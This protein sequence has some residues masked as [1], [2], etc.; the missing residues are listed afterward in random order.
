[1]SRKIIRQGSEPIQGAFQQAA[2]AIATEYTREIADDIA[3]RCR[4]ETS[5]GYTSYDVFALRTRLAPFV[6]AMF[7]RGVSLQFQGRQE[8]TPNN[9]T[10][11]HKKH[12]S[13]DRLV[14]LIAIPM[15]GKTE[16]T[17]TNEMSKLLQKAVDDAMKLPLDHAVVFDPSTPI[18][19]PNEVG[20]VIPVSW[21]RS[22]IRFV[23]PLRVLPEGETGTLDDYLKQFHFAMSDGLLY[24]NFR[25]FGGYNKLF[26]RMQQDIVL[27]LIE[28]W[29]RGYVA[30]AHCVAESWNLEKVDHKDESTA[31][32]ILPS[33]QLYRAT[34]ND[35]RF[36]Y[37][38]SSFLQQRIDG[39]RNVK[40][41]VGANN[42]IR[43]W[44]STALGMT[45]TPH[46]FNGP[47]VYIRVSNLNDARIYTTLVLQRASESY[48]KSFVRTHQ[49]LSWGK[50]YSVISRNFWA[51]Q[52]SPE[53]TDRPC[54]IYVVDEDK[55]QFVFSCLVPREM[56]L[57]FL[58]KEFRTRSIRLLV[59]LNDVLAKRPGIK[60]DNNGNVIDLHS[61]IEH[62]GFEM[63]E[64]LIRK[65]ETLSD[66]KP[67]L[68][69]G[70]EGAR[71]RGVTGINSTTDFA[72]GFEKGALGDK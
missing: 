70:S 67:V 32:F 44:V 10:S 43:H 68:V 64:E 45:N 52:R 34:W 48:G 16:V 63:P 14:R 49:R 6:R 11:E 58:H 47:Y 42:V 8:G 12:N 37:P 54:I 62:P 27:S 5:Y 26:S 65:N 29:N 19:D 4:D 35:D 1:M 20:S 66:T 61:I 51:T 3:W 33:P 28:M 69:M 9:T 7:G 50:L 60:T 15:I 41:E 24:G 17:M 13:H 56:S 30:D 46:F 21:I 59:Y 38:L 71:K 39:N 36:A 25:D 2:E 23:R 22:I 55:L 57:S 31:V 18:T 72:L 53:M 40:V